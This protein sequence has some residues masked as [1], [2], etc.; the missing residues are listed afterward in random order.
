MGSLVVRGGF[1]AMENV[2]LTATRFYEGE[3]LPAT[4]VS[5]IE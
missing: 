4:K 1:A 5:E 3:H 2:L